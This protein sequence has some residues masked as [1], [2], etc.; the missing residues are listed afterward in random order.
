MS[1]TVETTITRRGVIWLG[2]TCNLKCQFCYFID[3]RDSK[4][5]PEHAFMSLDKA[6]KICR[7]LVDVYNNNA[8]DLQGGEPTLFEGIFDLVSYCR[9]I[10]LK[11]TLITNA[12]LLDDIEV[13]RRYGSSGIDD[14]LVSVHGMGDVHNRLVGRADAHERQMKALRNLQK[15]GIPFRFNCVL[16]KPVLPQLSSIAR[17]ATQ[18][19]ARAVN[20][21]TF[22]PFAD[23]ALEGKR[24]SENVPPYSEIRTSL[25]EALDI[26]DDNDIEANVRYFPLCM[27]EERH[28]KSAY[29][30][31]QLPYDHHEWDYASWAWTGLQA[32]RMRGGDVSETF[33][34]ADY[35]LVVRYKRI[36]RKIISIPTLKSLLTSIYRLYRRRK[37]QEVPRDVLYRKIARAH[38][39]IHCRYAYAE[40]CS[41]CSLRGICDGF[42]GDYAVFFGMTEAEPVV[43]SETITDPLFYIRHQKNQRKWLKP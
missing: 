16:S 33:N 3:R 30:F 26:L 42:H 23:Q 43:L 32:Q 18:T 4:D 29:N 39:K 21:I 20:F 24:S 36:V 37:K 27:L 9:D 7:T 10:G 12:L 5:H 34:L 38:A 35:N 1:K 11:P 17:L 14:F 31:Q 2:Q 41:H 40:Q 22:N 28:R 6:K 19:G 15:I 13:C 8:V 25:T